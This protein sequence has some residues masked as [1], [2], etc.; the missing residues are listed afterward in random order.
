MPIW[1]IY[2]KYN[3]LA[4]LESSYKS[5]AGEIFWE[6]LDTFILHFWESR[7]PRHLQ[8]LTIDLITSLNVAPTCPKHEDA[9]AT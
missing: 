7:H 4:S 8:W 9:K 3:D 2:K 1:Q 5:Q 6:L